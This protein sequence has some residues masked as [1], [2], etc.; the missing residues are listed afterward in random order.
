[1]MPF[2]NM[3]HLNLSYGLLFKAITLCFYFVEKGTCCEVY[4]AKLPDTLIG[5]TFAEA[6]RV[7]HSYPFSVGHNTNAKLQI[8][9]SHIGAIMVGVISNFETVLNPGTD[10]MIQ[11]SEP[12]F[13]IARDWR[14]AQSVQKVG[15]DTSL[16]TCNKYDAYTL[17]C[18]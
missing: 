14:I 5:K 2:R 10:Y 7:R 1:M 9:Y 18:L 4:M 13:F 17:Q 12:A 16:G 8:I 11:G 3:V 15:D 6:T